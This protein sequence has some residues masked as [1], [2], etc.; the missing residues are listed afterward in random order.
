VVRVELD[1]D[2]SVQDRITVDSVASI[3]QAGI[4]GD[5]YVEI[6]LGTPGSEELPEGGMLASTDPIPFNE[7]AAKGAELLDNL[8]AFS[9][10]AER[11]V[12]SFE[13]AMGTESIASTFGSMSN[14]VQE[15]EDGDGI[16]HALI[17]D[18]GGMAAADL[19]RSMRELSS[20]L[21]RVNAILAEV[22]T[23][24]GMAHD[25]IYGAEDTDM[26]TLA[27][28][29]SAAERLESVL[30]KIDEGEGTLGALLNDPTVYEDLKLV[31]G[32]ARDST[33]L[34]GAIDY[35]RPDE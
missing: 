20:S 25:F 28:L 15:V 12:G 35:V 24:D 34:R 13:Q 4:L 1:V 32:G 19:K 11:I 27:A 2:S 18:Q 17:Y 30:R 6:S 29:R 22:E 23:G 33:L 8:V 5:M 7:L 16:L 21:G 26:S 31:L 9:A 3:H 14:I 10:S